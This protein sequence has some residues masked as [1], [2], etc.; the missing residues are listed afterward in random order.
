MILFTYDL[1][2]V[3]KIVIYLYKVPK[4]NIISIEKTNGI[5]IH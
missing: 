2:N 4:D 3:K 1:F 5:L